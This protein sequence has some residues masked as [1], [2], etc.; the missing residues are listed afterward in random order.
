MKLLT[1]EE[2]TYLAYQAG[3]NTTDSSPKIRYTSISIC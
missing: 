2:E 3:K 1:I